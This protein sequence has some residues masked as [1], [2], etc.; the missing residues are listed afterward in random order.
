MTFGKA[1][2]KQTLAA[3]S[4]LALL[5]SILAV[6]FIIVPKMR[7]L[8]SINT[9]VKTKEQELEAGKAKVAAIKKA[10]E[11]IRK[12]RKDLETLGIAV[13]NK[14]KGEEALLQVASAAG[15][16]E[17]TVKSATISAGGEG[18]GLLS[19]AVSTSGRYDNTIR[20]M[21]NLEKSLRPA[22]VSSFNFSPK[23][24]SADVDATFQI[25]L[26][27]VD[28]TVLSSPTATASGSAQSG[29]P[30]SAKEIIKE[31]K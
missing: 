26:P 21:E 24:G 31:A 5:A 25:A 16:A 14:E 23:Q 8:K 1:K 4:A 29:E 10:A 30:T 12:A 3:I 7:D 11:L 19:L 15:K 28:E 17:I 22:T 13:P 9:Q 2:L 27:F 18:R 6:I 20:F